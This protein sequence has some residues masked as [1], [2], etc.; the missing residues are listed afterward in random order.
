MTDNQLL[1]DAYI[2]GAQFAYD[3]AAQMLQN[4]ID[5]APTPEIRSLMGS[6]APVV[7]A[8]KLRGEAI[9][10]EAESYVSMLDGQTPKH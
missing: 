10:T 3:D 5:K 8:F 1:F 4:L 2:A 9:K 6:F 7:L